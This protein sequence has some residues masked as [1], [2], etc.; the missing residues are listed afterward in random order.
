MS[1]NQTRIMTALHIDEAFTNQCAIL[2]ACTDRDW[3]VLHSTQF[4]AEVARYTPQQC[5][6]FFT[7]NCKVPR[8]ERCMLFQFGSEDI[9]FDDLTAKADIKGDIAEY[10]KISVQVLTMLGP[11]ILR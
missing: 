3:E 6:A 9:I 2:C 8:L 1:V 7:G 5:S 10:V 11:K 4:R